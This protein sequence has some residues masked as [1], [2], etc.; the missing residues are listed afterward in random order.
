MGETRRNFSGGELQR[1]AIARALLAN[2][3]VLILDEATSHLDNRTEREVLTGVRNYAPTQI[4]LVISHRHQ[5]VRTADRVW[6]LTDGELTVA[7][8]KNHD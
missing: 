2:T 5:A 7:E 4:Q 3:P 6:T 8:G 1:L